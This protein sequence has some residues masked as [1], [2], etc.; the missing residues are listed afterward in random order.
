VLQPS[1]VITLMTDFGDADVYV[2]VMKGVIAAVFPG[3]RV[4]DLTHRV[5]AHDAAEAAWLLQDAYRYFPAGT[6]HV[7]VVDPGVGTARRVLGLRAG[8][9]LFLAPDNGILTPVHA[10]LGREALVEIAEP[11]YLLPNASRTFHG[12]DVFAPAAAHLAAGVALE[13]MGPPVADFVR[14]RLPEPCSL[15]GGVVRGEVVRVDGFGNLITNIR[16]ELVP[17]PDRAAVRVA[18][19]ALRGIQ[20]TYGV[21]GPGDVLALFGGFGV[22]EIAVNRG[23]AAQRLGV[24]RGQPVEVVPKKEA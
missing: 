18:G 21:A 1:G 5:P 11:R 4:V 16:R 22:L 2:G 13:A 10:E 7:A 23:S 6:V 24:G 14:L 12:R 8:N 17:R 3:A 19:V 15:H 20:P 9:H